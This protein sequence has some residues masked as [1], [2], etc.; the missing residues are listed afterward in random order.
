MKAR[1]IMTA[2]AGAAITLALPGD[3]LAQGKSAAARDKQQA[4][5]AA[6]QAVTQRDRDRER[7][8][9]RVSDRDRERQ[10]QWEREQARQ[11]ELDRQREM[12]R[13]REYER[14]REWERQ[15]GYGYDQR[16]GPS[17][18]RDGSGHP[19]KGRQ[20]CRDKGF[21]LGN[22]R[23]VWE[24]ARWDDVILRQ[25]R[26]RDQDRIGRGTLGDILGDVVLRRF[27]SYGRDQYGRGDMYG[28][29]YD[30]ADG[31]ILELTIGGVPFARLVDTNRN[32]RVNTVLL[33][34]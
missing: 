16:P 26:R 23:A 4:R 5:P 27:E 17:F 7:E 31:S 15:R 1:W 32:G 8:R 2:A 30:D 11:R 14:Q 18:C 9:Q 28:H 24:R 19:V 20:W 22:S 25:P 33:R 10:R 13:R 34:R 6:A 21:G 29:W 3:V 12:D